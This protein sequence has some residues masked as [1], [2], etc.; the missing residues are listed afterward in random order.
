MKLREDY[1][2][3]DA[4]RF[5]LSPFTIQGRAQ[6]RLRVLDL[7]SRGHFYTTISEFIQMEPYFVT[8]SLGLDRRSLSFKTV[9]TLLAERLEP[10]LDQTQG[11]DCRQKKGKQPSTTRQTINKSWWHGASRHRS[12]TWKRFASIHSCFLLG[13]LVMQLTVVILI[14]FTNLFMI[15]FQKRRKNDE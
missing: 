12:V 6:L 9:K 14:L 1:P 15:T 10:K 13:Y 5:P 3:I 7:G 8:V 11:F 2:T 4:N